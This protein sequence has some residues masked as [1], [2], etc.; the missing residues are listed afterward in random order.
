MQENVGS[1]PTATTRIYWHVALAVMRS[2]VNREKVS[3]ILTVPAKFVQR[4][5]LVSAAKRT[6]GVVVVRIHTAEP[7]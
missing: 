6:V 1:I 5:S 7:K 2:A 3:S 4:Q